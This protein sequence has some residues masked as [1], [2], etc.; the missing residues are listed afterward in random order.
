MR[1][2]VNVATDDAFLERARA[3][4]LSTLEFDADYE[5]RGEHLRERFR[6]FGSVPTVA[7]HRGAFGIEPV[8]YVFGES[9]VDA[10]ERTV[11][12]V[13]GEG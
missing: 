1:A 3:R 9:A 11:S 7:Y 12:L 2:A 5:E 13:G 6:E 4:D 10:V 8:A